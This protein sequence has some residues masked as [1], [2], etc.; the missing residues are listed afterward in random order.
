MPDSC[1]IVALGGLGEVGKNMTVYDCNG[2]IV[3]VDAGLA[4]P[5]DEHLG[6]D[7]VLP[8]F[9]FLRARARD[10]RAVILTHG[11]EDHV[12]ALPY[13]LRE[14][15]V[16][17]VWATRLTLGLVKSKLDEHGLLRAAQLREIHPDDEPQ[18]VG[19][20]RISFVRMAHS[21][22]DCVAV[23]LETP[24]GR[25]VHTSDY[26][27]D[28]TP[29][30]GLKTDVGRLAQVGND[31]VDLLLG[32]S[33]NA[34]RPGTTPS[35]RVVGEAFRQIIPLRRGRVLVSSFASNV[36]RMQ[37][38]VDVA[39]AVG[40]KV[41]VVGRSMR[42]NVNIARNLGY[43]D[44]PEGVLV[45]PPE[46]EELA[47]DEQ[48]ILCTGSQGEPLS[49]LTRIAYHD[50]PAIRVDRGDTVIISAKPVPGN[51]LRVHDA[52]NQLAKAGAEVLHQEIAP[53]HVS[54]HA[55]AE[56]IRT[57]L[58][59]L[60]P[61]SVMPIHGEF[62]MLAAHAQLARDAGVPA[63]SIVLA[64]NGA[65]VELTREGAHIVDEVE[66]GVTFVDGLGVGD[67]HDVALRD[68]QRLSEDGVLIIVATLAPTNGGAGAAGPPELIA[69]G[70]GD[71]S[72]ALIEELRDE[73]D[74]VLRECLSERISEIK[75]LQEHLHDEVGQ[76]IYDRT[77]RRPMI[78][79]VVVEV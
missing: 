52:I 8:D 53:V 75:L 13:L 33:T 15:A 21:I 76:L 40:R 42:K 2:S 64:E 51:E 35:E 61:R 24:A 10:V 31:G 43:M 37:Q 67:V 34:E 58:S 30:D 66:S 12:G 14:I 22:P 79:P 17:E 63:S 36:H 62:R 72:G 56:E 39:V 44:V 47:P 45:R 50:H 7:L 78:L 65:V 68:R 18:Q 4:F 54:G 46:L 25:I 71:D 6:V 1:R 28:H 73:A 55:C 70:F 38:A 20:F 23:V 26:K 27:L 3:V 69:R 48:L 59:L 32:D 19:S 60:R 11:H 74:R 5:R 16:P 57:I 29:V 77:R 9:A 41:C 49:A